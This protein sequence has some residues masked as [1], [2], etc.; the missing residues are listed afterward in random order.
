MSLITGAQILAPASAQGFAVPALNLS[1]YGML[2]AAF[3]VCE[4]LKSPLMVALGPKE[5]NWIGPDFI[6]AVLS[7]A[8]RSTVPTVLHWDHGAT[9]DEAVRAIKLGYSSVMIDASLEPFERNVEITSRVVEVAH[10][11]G[12][13][14]E[15]ELGT[16]GKTVGAD[17]GGTDDILYTEPAE[18]VEF[19][20]RTGV[21]SLAIAIGT[22]H[23]I[24]PKSLK[25]ELRLSLLDEIDEVVDVPLVLHG[26]SDNPDAEIREACRRG[27][28]KVNI[29]SDVKR[30][31][32]DAMRGVLADTS[33]LD[34]RLI[35]P[36]AMEAA[37]DLVRHKIDLFGS[38][39]TIHYYD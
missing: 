12:V 28:N 19:A 31:F 17:E 3:E 5:G 37:K 22:R 26:G 6:P 9:L 27:I 24:Y 2:M 35:V 7:R 13:S 34:P 32:Y 38:A 29:S 11:A 10:A 16:I 39:G 4:E 23:G 1:D 18:A 33:L 15:G 21:D 30:A 25:P 20:R 36:G 8:A 14:V